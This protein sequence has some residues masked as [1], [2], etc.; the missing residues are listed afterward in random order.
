MCG[1]RVSQLGQMLFIHTFVKQWFCLGD[2]TSVVIDGAVLS[3]HPEWVDSNRVGTVR[4]HAKEK[5]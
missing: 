4:A 2:S 1:H 3:A 5:V